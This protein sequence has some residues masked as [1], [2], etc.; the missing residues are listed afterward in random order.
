MAS[1]RFL[2]RPVRLALVL[3]ISWL[4]AA[5]AALIMTPVAAVRADAPYFAPQGIETFDGASW[6]G[7]TLGVTTQ[8]GVKNQFRNGRGRFMPAIPSV[9]LRQQD[10]NAPWRVDALYPTKDKQATLDGICLT[11]RGDERGAP[12]LSRLRGALGDGG[13]ERFAAERFEDWRVVAYPKKGVLL[14]VLDGR[15]PMA[16]L[17]TPGRIARAAETLGKEEPPVTR[18]IDP[19]EG[20]PRVVTFGSVDASLR[21]K[22]FGAK[23]ES[24]VKRD[25]EELMRRASA[26]GVLEF[27]YTG[28]GAYSLSITG[29]HDADKDKTGSVSCTLSGRTVYGPVRA[30]SYESFKIKR[31]GA[32]ETRTLED[33]DYLSAVLLAMRSAERDIAQQVRKQGPPPIEEERKR[34]WERLIEAYRSRPN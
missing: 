26:G 12:G 9:E 1:R 24:R 28:D 8:E 2:R 3:P 17:G 18:R 15:V 16:L 30:Y 13:E 20:K 34:A 22:D 27:S 5:T 6:S 31:A 10:D 14:F 19:H 7:I 32:G 29:D 25:L 4:W 33:T 23:D 21:L 11:Y